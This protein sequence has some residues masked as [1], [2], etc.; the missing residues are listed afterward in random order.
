M[1]IPSSL[2]INSVAF[3]KDANV[4]ASCYGGEFISFMDLRTGKEANPQLINAH[5]GLIES[6]SWNDLN[7]NYF[8]TGSV[9]GVKLWDIRKLVLTFDMSCVKLSLLFTFISG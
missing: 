6:S 8:L 5:S 9:D 2:A 3:S 4:L 1:S 7:S